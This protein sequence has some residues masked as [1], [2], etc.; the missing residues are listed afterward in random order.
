MSEG[1]FLAPGSEK[2]QLASQGWCPKC[3]GFG[4]LFHIPDVGRAPT[5]MPLRE[6]GGDGRR[7][8]RIP[9]RKWGARLRRSP[10]RETFRSWPIRQASLTNRTNRGRPRKAYRRRPGRPMGRIA[11]PR[12]VETQKLH[13]DIP[14]RDPRRLRFPGDVGLG[15]LQLGRGAPRSVGGEGQ[16][17]RLAAQLGS[18]GRSLRPG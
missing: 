7:T 10:R 8:A 2:L 11:D 1:S 4:E 6:T 14:A 9:V 12:P 16:R 18:T 13:G 17:I 3:R 15:Y 5:A